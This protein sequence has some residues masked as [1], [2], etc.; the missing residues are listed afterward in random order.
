MTVSH[1][2]CSDN[3]DGNYPDPNDSSGYI[4]CVAHEHAY[5]MPCA[6]GP[7]GKR[8]YYVADSGPNPQTSRCDYPEVAS[9][10]PALTAGTLRRQ[11]TPGA[12]KALTATLTNDGR[13]VEAAR[14]VFA[15]SEDRVLCEEYTDN[16]G[17]ATCHTVPANSG[18][19]F[20]ATFPGGTANPEESGGWQA[21]E[22]V[23]ILG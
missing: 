7:G 23:G 5:A 2:D 3:E 22:A 19:S 17:V 20:T 10:E 12:V 11:G 6:M 9:V 15:D 14:I 4:A 8:L 13:P 1:F 21:A 16:R 18:N